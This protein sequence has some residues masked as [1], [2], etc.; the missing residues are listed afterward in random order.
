MGSPTESEHDPGR[1]AE[2][3]FPRI[4]GAGLPPARE[5]VFCH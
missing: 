1:G 3:I 5:N 4:P 2:R